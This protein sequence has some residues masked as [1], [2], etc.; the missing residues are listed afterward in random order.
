M[1]YYS[2]LNST[3]QQSSSLDYASSVLIDEGTT[4]YSADMIGFQN[5]LSQQILDINSE[6]TGKIAEITG[7]FARKDT[8]Q[9]QLTSALEGAGAGLEFAKGAKTGVEKYYKAGM[10]FKGKVEDMGKGISDK[11]DDFK[12][13]AEGKMSELQGQAE[14][15]I[16]DLRT[17]AGGLYD[18]QS[19]PVTGDATPQTQFDDVI[20]D[21]VDATE[22]VELPTR[23]P[24]QAEAR[25]RDDGEVK[26]ETEAREYKGG[27]LQDT[28]DAGRDTYQ[29]PFGELKGDLSI[30]TEPTIEPPAELGGEAGAEVG[31]EAGAESGITAAVEGGSA[32][33][34]EEAGAEVAVAGAFDPVV[35]VIAGGLM[36]AGAVVGIMD[37]F[38]KKKSEKKIKRKQEKADTLAQN[39]QDEAQA[40][41]D[42]QVAS[43]D[44]TYD[45]IRNNIT[46]NTHA[47]VAIGVQNMRN[48]YKSGGTF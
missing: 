30:P 9:E 33:G 37:V 25:P 38:G 47:G 7:K 8:A 41:Y 2:S 12:G 27:E 48:T 22:G 6:Y 26:E 32:V 1:D 16:S 45:T 43:T 3:S 39:E 21:D 15:K 42:A 31:A 20:D 14:S 28:L 46:A 36:V 11:V 18:G 10:D 35:D 34:L 23:T 44:K 17:Q 29:N 5:E 19:K 4:N 24:I 40:Q 13:Q